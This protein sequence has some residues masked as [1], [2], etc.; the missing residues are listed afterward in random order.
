MLRKTDDVVGGGR[1]YGRYVPTPRYDLEDRLIAFA[2]Q[3]CVACEQLRPSLVGKHVATQLV[4]SS[5][6]PLAN[7]GE[8]QGAESRRD[9]VHKL[10]V[11]LKELRETLTW[12]KFIHHTELGASGCLEAA[13]AECN[14]LIAIFVTSIKT[15]S[16]RG[17]CRM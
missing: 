12:L 2:A 5:T 13:T 17:N 8:A 6:S 9:F 10:R 1:Q 14:E 15:A 7:Y 11:C 16:A 4:R 3:V